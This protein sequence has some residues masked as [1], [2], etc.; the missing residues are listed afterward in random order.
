MKIFIAICFY[1]GQHFLSAALGMGEGNCTNSVLGRRNVLWLSLRA[2]QR[3]IA[4]K[5][6]MDW[7]MGKV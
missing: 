4:E 2:A 6:R 5:Q 7:L 3:D 1:S